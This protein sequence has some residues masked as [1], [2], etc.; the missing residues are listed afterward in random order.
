MVAHELGFAEQEHVE[1]LLLRERS[2]ASVRDRLAVGHFDLAQVLA[3]MPIASNIGLWPLVTPLIV[4]MVLGLGGSA[5]TVSTALWQ[6]MAGEG[7]LPNLEPARA[8]AALR[9]VVQQRA[10][11]GAEPLRF[12][13]VHPHS[14]QNYELRYWLAAC[15]IP[16]G[17]DVELSI[18]PPPAM[19]DALATGNIDGCCVGEPWNSAAVA[20]GLGHIVTTK[21]AIWPG[22]P[23]KVLGVAR[24]W[25]EAHPYALSGLLRALHRASQWCADPANLP[26]LAALLARPAYL[27]CPAEWLLPVLEGR[28]AT[29]GQEVVPV[30]D[31][32]VPH[33]RNATCPE[34]RHALWL[35]SQMVRWSQTSFSA[36]DAAVAAAT[37]RP[38]MYLSALAPLG[39]TAPA[40][41]GERFFDGR[42]FDPLDIPGYLASLPGAQ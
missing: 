39:A 27:H 6:R 7:A 29:G 1:L 36:T 14:A 25:A 24:S 11:A 15:G 19:P 30:T 41:E 42:G 18:L 28:I 4:P 13:V 32:F 26:A 23:D 38:D 33:A 17:T 2:W 10:R 34:P 22:G 9:A 21:A 31:F 3:P 12:A 5:V 37:W 35:Y 16:P 40:T 20:G 8:G